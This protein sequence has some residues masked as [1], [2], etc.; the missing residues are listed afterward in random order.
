MS[1]RVVAGNCADA[2][3]DSEERR[4]SCRDCAL[5]GQRVFCDL[6][7]EA[8]T[9]FDNIARINFYSRGTRLFWEGQ[10]PH[11]VFIL[12]GGQAKLSISSSRGKSL[13]RVA[14]LGEILGLSAILSEQP[15]EGSAEMLNGGQVKFVRRDLFMNF[16]RANGAASLRAAEALSRDYQ[17]VYEQVRAVALSDSVAEKL[18]KL[19]LYWCARQGKETEQG[20]HLKLSLTHGEIAQ[21]IGVSRETVTRLIGEFRVKRVIELKGSNLFVPNKAALERMVNQ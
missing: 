3:Q 12:C 6:P 10:A 1:L 2:I 5:N 11:G 14:E 13:M 15:Y 19:L 21:M 9:M 4:E 7:K 18:A 16:L 17:A 20:I 8:L